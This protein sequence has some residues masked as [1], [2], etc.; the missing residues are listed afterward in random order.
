MKNKNIPTTEILPY[1][2]FKKFGAKTLMDDELLAI[3]LR[4]GTKG[5]S[6]TSLSQKILS[7]DQTHQGLTGLYH[8]LLDDLMKIKGIGEVKAIQ[9]KCIAELS[10]RIAV[11]SASC[12][13]CFTEPE[14]I[15]N[16]CMEEMRHLEFERVFLILLDGKNALIKKICISQ[17]SVN[18]SIVSTREIF[19]YALQYGASY[20]ILVHNH[21]SGSS[22]PSQADISL[23]KKIITASHIMNIPL[24]DHIIIGD[25]TY[26]SLAEEGYIERRK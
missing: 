16:L 10:M 13:L 23:T 18:A 11:Q 19:I 24:I 17:G 6:A 15:A 20:F 1:E 2:K 3:I 12:S 4:T 25:R 26:T 8:M 14:S 21:P 7:I 5:E 9:I 22:N